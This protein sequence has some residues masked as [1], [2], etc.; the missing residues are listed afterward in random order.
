MRLEAKSAELLA[1][2]LTDGGEMLTYGATSGEPMAVSGAALVFQNL[3]YK[4]WHL[5]RF[6]ASLDQREQDIMFR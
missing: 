4:G 5:G 6:L 1:K 3:S 2:C